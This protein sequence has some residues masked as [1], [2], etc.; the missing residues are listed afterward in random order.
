[1]EGTSSQLQVILGTETEDVNK[2]RQRD[3]RGKSCKTDQMRRP[4]GNQKTCLFCGGEHAFKKEKC[5]AWGTK[6]LICNHFAKVCRKPKKAHRPNTS[7]EQIKTEASHSDS[8]DVDFITSITAI[9]SAVNSGSSSTYGY[10][11]EIYTV[12]EIGNQ[13]VTLQIE[14]G[15]LIN[16][17]MEALVGNRVIMKTTKGLVIWM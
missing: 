7:V 11:K 12:M 15:A 2:I 8:S 17:I 9:I 3:S 10:A 4:E 14:S 16:I 1:M 5:P 13:A 6:C